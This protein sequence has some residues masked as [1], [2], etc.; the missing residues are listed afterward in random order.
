[1]SFEETETA[2]IWTCEGCGKVAAFPPTDFNSRK[3]ELK[4][5]G[6]RFHLYEETGHEGWGRSWTHSCPKCW[7][8]RQQ[9]SILDRRFGKPTAVKG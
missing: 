9:T 2:F 8:E 5:R 6:W 4:E 1:M 3:D 7:K